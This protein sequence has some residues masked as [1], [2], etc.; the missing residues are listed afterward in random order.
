MA[1]TRKT[2]NQYITEIENAILGKDSTLDVRVGSLSKIFIQPLAKVAAQINLDLAHLSDIL[3]LINWNVMTDEELEDFA[4]NYFVVRDLGGRATGYVFFR[5]K[6]KPTV[7]IVI[8]AG[9]PVGSEPDSQGRTVT[10]I[11]TQSVTMFAAFADTY[12]NVIDQVYEIQAPI[13]AL[14]L[15]SQASLP[16]GRVNRLLRS[17]AGIDSVIN[18]DAISLVSDRETNEELKNR[19]L[20]VNSGIQVSVP[21]GLKYDILSRKNITDV[22]LVYKG[23]SLLTR[24]DKDVGAI[25]AYVL[26]SQSEQ[27]IEVFRFNGD[28]VLRKQPVLSLVSVVD[29]SSVNRTSNF[30]LV[31]DTGIYAESVRASDIIEYLGGIDNLIGTL[32]TV[33]YTVDKVIRDLQSIYEAE[34]ADVFAR[35]LLFRRAKKVDIVIIGTVTVLGGF[36]AV[37]VKQNVRDRIFNYVNGLKLGNDVE[38]ADVIFEAKN[39]SGVDNVVFTDFRKVTQVSGTVNDIVIEKNEY[40]RISSINLVIL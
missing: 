32:F 37:V 11:V 3:S 21:S 38:R 30:N 1:I 2:E 39:V 29:S 19:I 13:E 27:I 35:D 8:P 22:S 16:A 18:K 24:E 25:D 23:D 14:E 9:F 33:T 15:G 40:A 12:F 5:T 10:Y 20:L 6:T 36:D 28:Y 4:S 17:I 26:D 34:D 31:K 7:D